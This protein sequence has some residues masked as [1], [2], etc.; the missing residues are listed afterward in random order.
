MIK[1]KLVG[2]LATVVL[3]E[4]LSEAGRLTGNGNGL[5][6]FGAVLIRSELSLEELD[7]RGH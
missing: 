3:I 7:I 5:Q 6:Y 1:L 4:S 2:I